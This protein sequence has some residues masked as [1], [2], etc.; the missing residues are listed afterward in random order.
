[1]LHL[2][3]PPFSGAA[4]ESWLKVLLSFFFLL[5]KKSLLFLVVRAPH[6]TSTGGCQ[7]PLVQRFS[8]YSV[9]HFVR[10][11]S[12]FTL[13]SCLFWRSSP[14]PSQKCIDWC[15]L[16][17]TAP[18][19]GQLSAAAAACWKDRY[20][21]RRGINT[22]FNLYHHCGSHGFP[23]NHPSNLGCMWGFLVGAQGGSQ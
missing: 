15:S 17:T 9:S 1:M 20:M 14:L 6:S 16:R 11:T 8:V 4:L 7:I 19:H 10:D 21:L 18:V 2:F 22:W 3:V 23:W 13:P 5:I 12:S